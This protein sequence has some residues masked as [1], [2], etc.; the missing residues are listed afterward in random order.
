MKMGRHPLPKDQL[1]SEI[2]FF[3]ATQ[4]ERAKLETEARKK[5]IKLSL[6]IRT[7]IFPQ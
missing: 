6:F 5:R 3:R 4:E 1:K 2:L 7:F